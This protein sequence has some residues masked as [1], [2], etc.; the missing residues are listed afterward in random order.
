VEG[1]VAGAIAAWRPGDPIGEIV[2]WAWVIDERC[3]ST[4]LVDHPRW[5]L[6]VPPGG[7][8]RRGEHPRDGA[9]RELL[10]ETGVSGSLLH[11]HP[12]LVDVVSDETADGLPCSTFGIAY[13]FV[14]DAA[15]VV[16]PAPGH[17]AAWW[18]LADPPSRRAEH[19]WRRLTRHLAALNLD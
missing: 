19:H 16:A 5:R 4:L 18:S 17:A 15:A 12:A 3:T 13:V 11:D 14:V 2:G 7:R 1:D 9:A 10:E 8:T 6:W